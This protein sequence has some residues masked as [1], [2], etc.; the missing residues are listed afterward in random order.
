MATQD[1]STPAARAPLDEVMMAMDVVDTLR[2]RRLVVERELGAEA[3]DE[4]LLQRLRDIYSSQGIEV[5]DA[6]LEEGVEALRR[7]RFVYHRAG[8]GFSRTLAEWYVARGRWGKWIAGAGAILLLVWAGNYFVGASDDRAG[9]TLQNRLDAAYTSV[10]RLNVDQTVVSR[11]DGMRADVSAA[12]ESD[13][14]A[15]ARAGIIN[16]ESLQN[17]LEQSY[18]LRVVS[19]PGEP[20]GVWRIPDVNS[21]ARNYYLIVEAIQDDGRPAELSIRSEEDGATRALTKWGLRVDPETFQRFVDDKQADGIID[22]PIVGRKR[23]GS[24]EPDY[25]IDTPGGAIA[26]W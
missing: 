18:E 14:L 5:P 3:R 11:A 26:E 4:S 24:L 22:E 16:L 17:R 21:S 19:R 12:I 25:A 2:H 8:S 6:V 7:D 10:T 13:D 20:S 23:R 9:R 1:T 15:A